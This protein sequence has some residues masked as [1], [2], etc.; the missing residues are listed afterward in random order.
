VLWWLATGSARLTRRAIEV[1]SDPENEI[2]LSPVS[3]WE[4]LVKH[5]IKKLPMPTPLP[6]L[7]A[8]LREE[9]AVR[10]LP[11]TEAAA[12]RMQDL[13]PLHRDPFDR[14][15]IC[16]ALDESMTLLTPDEQI[17]AYPVPTLWE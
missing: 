8:T 4:L 6:D 13:P 15:L 11:L 3:I 12:M 2:A 9:R 5:G 7:L 1:C 17:R 10:T 14:M 16:Q